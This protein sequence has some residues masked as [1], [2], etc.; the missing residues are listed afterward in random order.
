MIW[1]DHPDGSRTCGFY[2]IQRGVTEYSLWWNHPK[3]YRRL[4]RA[5]YLAQIKIDAEQHRSEQ[6]ASYKMDQ[7]ELR[8]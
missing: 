7:D 4:A 1:T 3:T 8:P 6:V 2:T 5:H